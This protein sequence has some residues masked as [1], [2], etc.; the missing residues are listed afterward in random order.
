VSLECES[1]L[2]AAERGD[3]VGVVD[4]PR[5]DRRGVFIST[6]VSASDSWPFVN[7]IMRGRKDSLQGLFVV[8][9]RGQSACARAGAAPAL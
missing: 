1:P 7:N 5:L 9:S 6:A 8:A 3:V 4:G 2:A